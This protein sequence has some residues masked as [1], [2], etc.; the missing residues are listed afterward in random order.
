MAIVICVW[1]LAYE[2]NQI[3]ILLTERDLIED[4][5]KRVLLKLMLYLLTFLDLYAVMQTPP[6]H[7]HLHS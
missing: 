4:L 3:Q 7:L 1:L 6:F 2:P 5:K